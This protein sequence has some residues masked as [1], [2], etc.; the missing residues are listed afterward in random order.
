MHSVSGRRDEEVGY[1]VHLADEASM[2]EKAIDFLHWEDDDVKFR[3][4]EQCQRGIENSRC[5]ALNSTLGEV[6]TV[7]DKPRRKS[8]SQQSFQ[9][10]INVDRLATSNQKWGQGRLLYVR[11]VEFVRNVVHTVYGPHECRTMSST[12]KPVVSKIAS[13][14]HEYE[15]QPVAFQSIGEGKVVIDPTIRNC[16]DKGESKPFS[17]HCSPHL[18][19]LLHQTIRKVGDSLSGSIIFMLSKQMGYDKLYKD[20]NKKERDAHFNNA[21]FWQ[22]RNSFT[23]F[24]LQIT[25]HIVIPTDIATVCPIEPCNKGRDLQNAECGGDPSLLGQWVLYFMWRSLR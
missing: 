4:A 12:M 21:G 19:H 13:E 3:R 22:C 15:A 20:R 23:R 25:M 9:V 2:G 11:V 18:H 1:V 24:E 10:S 16:R 6:Y 17:K 5:N 7:T 8:F 14:P